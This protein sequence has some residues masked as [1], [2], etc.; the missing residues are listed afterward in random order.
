MSLMKSSVVVGFGPHQMFGGSAGLM[1]ACGSPG[2]AGL[3]G[4]AVCGDPEEAGEGVIVLQD[5]KDP[6]MVRI[7]TRRTKPASLFIQLSALLSPV[8]KLIFRR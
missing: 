7:H 1:T 6:D 5:N 4:L 2:G 3:T 8:Q